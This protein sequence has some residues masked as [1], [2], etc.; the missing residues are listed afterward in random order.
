MVMSQ[1]LGSIKSP[2][3]VWM[4]ATVWMYLV[5]IWLI[6]FVW[7]V[8]C[9][10][11]CTTVLWVYLLQHAVCW[12]VLTMECRAFRL[13]TPVFFLHPFCVTHILAADANFI[14]ITNE[15]PY[16]TYIFIISD[17]N[18]SLIHS[19]I[20]R[21]ER[22]VV[23]L[24]VG[25]VFSKW[26]VCVN[27]FEFCFHRQLR[28][29]LSIILSSCLCLCWFSILLFLLCI[30]LLLI[31]LLMVPLRVLF[32]GY[33]VIGVLLFDFLLVYLCLVSNELTVSMIQFVTMCT[34]PR[35]AL[36]RYHIN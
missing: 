24:S 9:Q 13:L 7:L 15:L 20:Y 18:V 3:D 27:Q 10:R 36:V 30:S 35:N 14:G 23:W 22:R 21:R 34:K 5:D 16:F 1:Y 6:R 12:F 4:F 33:I 31:S 8:L 32:C 26:N 25:L 17:Q 28:S 29:S 11:F 2:S 19:F